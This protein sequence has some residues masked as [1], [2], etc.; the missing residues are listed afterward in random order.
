MNGYK[1]LHFL[2]ADPCTSQHFKGFA[3]S[4]S[5]QLPGLKNLNT[6]EINGPYIFILN[7]DSENGAGEHWCVAYLEKVGGKCEFFDPYGIPPWFYGFDRLLKKYS[8]GLVYSQKCVQ[9][10][11]SRACSHHCLLYSFYRCRGYSMNEI[12]NLYSDYDMH[13]NEKFAEKFVLQ[14]GRHYKLDY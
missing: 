11:T 2:C 7:T 3:M 1:I 12:L 9:C 8:S 10:L 14:F 6:S 4:D 13:Y 5:K